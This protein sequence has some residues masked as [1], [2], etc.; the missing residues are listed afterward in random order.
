MEHSEVKYEYVQQQKFIGLNEFFA[1]QI[2]TDNIKQRVNLAHHSK[3]RESFS[4]SQYIVY[5]MESE[6]DRIVFFLVRIKHN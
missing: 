3:D 2:Q 6:T 4:S 5:K 1:L